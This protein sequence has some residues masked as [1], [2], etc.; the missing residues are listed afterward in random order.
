M[1]VSASSETRGNEHAFGANY[2]RRADFS[3]L[4]LAEV[5]AG[6]LSDAAAMGTARV[7]EQRLAAAGLA[8]VSPELVKVC[9]S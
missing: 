5:E 3:A 7:W 9:A 4:T 2:P 1:T 6:L 8:I